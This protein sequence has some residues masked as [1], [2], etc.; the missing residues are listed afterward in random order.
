[1]RTIIQ[2]NKRMNTGYDALKKVILTLKARNVLDSRKSLETPNWKDYCMQI[3]AKLKRNFGVIRTWPR[4]YVHLKGLDWSKRRLCTIRT[5]V[6]RWGK[7]FSH[8]NN[9]KKERGVCIAL[10]L[11]MKS[12]SDTPDKHQHRRQ[13]RIFTDQ[14]HA[15]HLGEPEG[16]HAL[17]AA[18]SE[19][20]KAA[21]WYRQQLMN[22]SRA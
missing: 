2:R 5:E 9:G 3:R 21:E 1:M 12:G 17:W 20:T 22:L 13:N 16:C 6:H 19:P 14:A 4:I 10:S 8:V 18:P 7:A 15:L 11:V